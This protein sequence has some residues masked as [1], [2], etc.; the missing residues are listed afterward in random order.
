MILFEYFLLAF[1]PLPNQQMNRFVHIQFQ[2]SVRL[3]SR[4]IWSIYWITD[5]SAKR[6][7]SPTSPFGQTTNA[8]IDGDEYCRITIDS[9]T[10]SYKIG[11]P[12]KP[13]T[14]NGK[15]TRSASHSL[16]TTTYMEGKFSKTTWEFEVHLNILDDSLSTNI[17]TRES[18]QQEID[19]S[20]TSE[21]ACTAFVQF[22]RLCG[23]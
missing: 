19:A 3:N 10:N 20:F 7:N 17:H 13:R 2:W 16:L 5:S 6:T 23:E 15:Q 18:I 9:L 12:V 22:C 4:I 1:T 11:S 14:V 21:L 8:S